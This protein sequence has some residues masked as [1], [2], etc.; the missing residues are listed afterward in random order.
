MA[1]RFSKLTRPECRKLELG[2]K[3]A[4][5]GISFE[6]LLSGDG[7]YSVNVMVDGT[8]IHRVIGLESAGV[9]RETCEAFISKA[10]SDSRE[11]RLSLPKGRKVALSF[12]QAS[13]QYLSRLEEGDGKDT[14]RK[15]AI[16]RKHLIPFFGTTPI[17][18]ITSFDVERFKKHRLS[19][20]SRLGGDRH[21]GQ[22]GI[23]KPVAPATVQRELACLSHLLK[24]AE[25]WGWIKTSPQIRGLKLDNARLTYL[26]QTQVDRVLESAKADRSFE[27]YAYLLISLETSMRM[28]EILSIRLEHIDLER[29]IIHIPKAKS[30]A[31]DQPITGRLAGY[32][33]DRL[34]I[35]NIG[36]LFPS[37]KKGHHMVNIRKPFIRVVQSADLDPTVINR[38]TTRHTAI[39][40]LVQAGV[41]L[42]AVQ[43]ISAHKDIKMVAR[44]SHQ[45]GAHL[46][47]A[48]DKLEERYKTAEE[49]QKGPQLSLVD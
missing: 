46:Q 4:E 3:I 23:E 21:S 2:K 48:M 9:T 45:N 39:T 24:K 44:Y 28:S 18:N 13:K 29:R 31:R 36:W 34:K 15:E 8:R 11:E 27:I 47:E 32:L 40:H 7:R 41:D 38:H 43:R 42:P 5:H 14:E 26:T 19:S 49:R 30:G 37:R 20:T 33:A 22:G 17:S 1:L 10:K 16:L 25:E 35:S 12:T 6:R